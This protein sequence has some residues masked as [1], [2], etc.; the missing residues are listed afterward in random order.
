MGRGYGQRRMEGKA[1]VSREQEVKKNVMSL[2]GRTA[3]MEEGTLS[4]KTLRWVFLVCSEN[5]RCQCVW[6]R[7]RARERMKD[8]VNGHGRDHI[9]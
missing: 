8:K 9:M 3:F 7:V 1:S 5:S 2:S 6:H 4:A